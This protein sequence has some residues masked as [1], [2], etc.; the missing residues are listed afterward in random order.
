MTVCPNPATDQVG[1]I[2]SQDADIVIYNIM[3]QNVMNVE[4]H[5]GANTINISNL[6]SGIYFINAGTDTQKLIVK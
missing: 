6:T 3:G 5:V 2:L 1:I 4:G